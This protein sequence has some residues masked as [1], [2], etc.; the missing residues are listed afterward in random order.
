MHEQEQYCRSGLVTVDYYTG[1]LGLSKRIDHFKKVKEDS[2]APDYEI[3]F[4][5]GNSWYPLEKW[6]AQHDCMLFDL[7]IALRNEEA[8]KFKLK[9]YGL[10]EEQIAEVK[11]GHYIKEIPPKKDP[12]SESLNTSESNK[13]G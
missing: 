10:T 12:K 8:A 13:D 3:G 5:Y 1:M 4:Q 9:E 7:K 11:K 2:K 6:S